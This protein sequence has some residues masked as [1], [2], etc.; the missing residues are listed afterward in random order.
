MILGYPLNKILS[1]KKLLAFSFF[2]AVALAATMS[3]SS[4]SSTT[5]TQ[6]DTIVLAQLNDSLHTYTPSFITVGQH[7]TCLLRLSCGCLFSL[8]LDSESGDT[9]AFSLTDLDT[10]ATTRKS[11]HHIAI[12]SIASTKGNTAIYY[13]SAVDHFNNTKYDTLRLF[14]KY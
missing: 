7:D 1:M 9:S 8:N 11:P 13:F 4:C 12:T 14:T 5:S 3:G 10:L 6:P 2:V